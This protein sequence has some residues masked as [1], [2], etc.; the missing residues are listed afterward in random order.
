MPEI[1]RA[2]IPLDSHS[3]SAFQFALRY[4]LAMCEKTGAGDI[5][6]LTHTKGQ[7]DHTSLSRL[8]GDRTVKALTKG[9]V[10]LEQGV[11]LHAETMRTLTW[12]ARKSVIIVYYA[13]TKIL[14]FAD[15]LR[16]VVGVVAVPDLPGE[17]DDWSSRWGVIVHGEERQEP[18]PLID[19]KIVVCALEGLTRMVNLSTGLGHPRDKQHADE[20]LRILRAKGHADPTPQIKSWA[21]R[22]GWRPGDAVKLEALSRKI[23]QLKAKPSLAGFYNPHERYNR[24]KSGEA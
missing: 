21:I 12:P 1:F 17:A 15:G 7:L 11:R 24:W 5:I 16:N 22:N 3:T 19:D 4:A 10:A 9:P 2:L 14:D 18:A 20:V 23:W 13:E 8:L 6:L